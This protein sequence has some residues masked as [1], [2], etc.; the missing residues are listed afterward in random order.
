V[1]AIP[2]H[3]AGLPLRR[4]LR[5]ISWVAYTL[6]AGLFPLL[7]TFAWIPTLHGRLILVLVGAGAAQWCWWRRSGQFWSIAT[8]GIPVTATFSAVAIAPQAGMLMGINLMFV[9][10]ALGAWAYLCREVEG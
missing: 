1:A 4:R 5:R 3:L 6:F 10:A 8:W 9:S 7:L 2:A